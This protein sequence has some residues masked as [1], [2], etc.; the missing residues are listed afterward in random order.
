MA[1]QVA[2]KKSA[3]IK[4]RTTEQEK[5]KIAHLAKLY[6][7]GSMSLWILHGALN[8]PRKSLVDKSLRQ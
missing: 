2:I 6:A 3:E 4:I 5:K 1:K 7:G 8:A